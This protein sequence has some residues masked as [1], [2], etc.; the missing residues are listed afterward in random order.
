MANFSFSIRSTF[1]LLPK[2]DAIETTRKNLEQ[3]FQRLTGYTESEELKEFKELEGYILSDGFKQAKAS[4]LALDYK[5]TEEYQKELRYLKLK[6][7]KKVITYFK[8]EQS[9]GLSEFIKTESSSEL[10]T[11]LELQT[12]ITSAGHQSAKEALARELVE[13]QNKQKEYLHL[14][15]SKQISNYF[16]TRN[17][18]LLSLYNE[19]TGSDELMEYQELEQFSK[20]QTLQQF[21]TG[22]AEQL[23]VEKNKPKRLSILRKD[24]EIKAF[25]K[26]KGEEPTNKPEK[27][28]ELEELNEYLN[29]ADYSQKLIEL[30]YK[31][32]SE[33][34][35][36]QKF[37]ELKKLKRF[38][39]YFKF[40]VS[41]QLSEF[42]AFNES[43]EL[44]NYLELEAY[45]TSPAYPEKL[46]SLKYSN[47][48]GYK[49]EQQ[50]NELK[51][52]AQI[53]AWNQFKVS[54]PYLVY[55]QVNDSE[56]LK[57]Y[58]ELNE[59]VNSEKFQEYKAYLL[60]KNK[61]QK[62][63][64]Y[65]KEQRY[66]ELRHSENIKWYFS[67][68]DSTKFDSLKQWRLTF[69]D[70]FNQGKI[71][72][73][74][75]MNS[76]FWGKMLL[77]D[78]YVIAGEKQFFT[79]NK[80]LEHNGTTVKLVTKQEK[81]TGKVWHDT[82]GFIPQ[83]F[84]YTS[85]MLSTAHSFRQKYGRFEAKIKLNEA[86]PVYQAF[87]LKGERITPEVHVLRFNMDKRNRLQLSSISGENSNQRTTSKL[88]GSSFT[89]DF[90]IYTLDWTP[91][92]ISWKI[93]GIELFATT[94]NIP[95]EPMYVLLSSGV[96]KEAEQINLPAAF[97]I[98]WV[99]CYE[100]N[101]SGN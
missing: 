45:V 7:D 11:Y 64:E 20:S 69:E 75:W 22:L 13:E 25:L 61:F 31:N 71:D 46:K 30:Q 91:E 92:R 1:G 62:S 24:T 14:K 100:K 86:F 12:L 97:E 70:D 38:K 74:K 72:S 10:A 33:Y 94:A 32:T 81:I 51:N 65:Q 23:Q 54:K 3:E 84:D 101:N 37:Y 43:S 88:N 47:S 49:S 27:L 58:N 52:S 5:K 48:D 9:A 21:K 35:K 83:N 89:K 99:R 73:E 15:K 34:Q 60:D 18:A 67:V 39:D 8:V 93:N 44:A 63:D 17:S 80:N 98:D 40:S 41:N 26:Q 78:S 29:S 19:L 56:L 82:H 95:D 85:A 87:W 16:K 53:K 57:E 90:F 4:I 79:D 66:N 96:K 50:F 2:T 77:K 42:L 6:K 76:F 68:K 59:L 55:S 36:E 28:I